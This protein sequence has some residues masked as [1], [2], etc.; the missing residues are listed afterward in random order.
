MIYNVNA[1]ISDVQSC[2]PS[3][4]GNVKC[5]DTKNKK[6]KIFSGDEHVHT[7]KLD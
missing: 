5:S 2:M 6:I 1:G 7:Y 3:Q 4:K